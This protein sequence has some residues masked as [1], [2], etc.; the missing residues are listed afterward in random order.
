MDESFYPGQHFDSLARFLNSSTRSDFHGHGGLTN[1]LPQ[2]SSPFIHHIS[3]ASSSRSDPAPWEI[4]AGTGP[5]SNHERSPKAGSQL[6]ILRGY[7]SPEWLDRIGTKYHLEPEFLRRHL[8]DIIPGSTVQ[9]FDASTLP[10]ASRNVFQLRFITVGTRATNQLAE[11]T[12][13]IEN[14]R[15]DSAAAM[16]QYRQT[17]RRRQ[18]WKFGDSVVRDYELYDEEHFTIEQNITLHYME[19]EKEPGETGGRDWLCKYQLFDLN[20]ARHFT[21]Y[22]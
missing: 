17:L 20:F 8:D 22:P 21:E 11:A 3:L 19:L 5:K 12:T 18:G 1:G 16:A 10:S 4:L 6:L 7:P 9:Q 14:L 15:L 13:E 2:A